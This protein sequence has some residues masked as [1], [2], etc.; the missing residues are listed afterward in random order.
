ML[1]PTGLARAISLLRF[2]L[3]ITGSGV[4]EQQLSRIDVNSVDVIA[5]RVV[6][7]N[8]TA[9]SPAL[10]AVSAVMSIKNPYA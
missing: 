6:R 9:R 5:R 8:Q 4:T 3:A 7:V 10:H 2:G 1:K